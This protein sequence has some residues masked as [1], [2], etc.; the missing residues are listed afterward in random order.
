MASNALSPETMTAPER[1]AEAAD[2]IAAGILRSRLRRGFG[3][4]VHCRQIRADLL[5]DKDGRNSLAIEADTS[6][7]K[8]VNN[9][10]GGRP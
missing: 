3:G 2:L 9:C 4:Q 5:G 7:Y 6:L 1:V 10:N 8:G